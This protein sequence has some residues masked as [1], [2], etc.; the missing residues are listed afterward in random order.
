MATN[1]KL[2]NKEKGF[3]SF[4]HGMISLINKD[5]KVAVIEN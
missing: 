4:I 5:F 2:S 1:K 3:D